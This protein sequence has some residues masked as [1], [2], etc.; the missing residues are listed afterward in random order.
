MEFVVYIS[1]DPVMV[2]E[3]KSHPKHSQ[4]QRHYHFYTAGSQDISSSKFLAFLNNKGF[5][6][7]QPATLFFKMISAVGVLAR[8]LQAMYHII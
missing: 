6:V 2:P 3:G 1:T 5:P 4:D 7:N 8:V